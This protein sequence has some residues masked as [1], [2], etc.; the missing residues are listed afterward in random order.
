MAGD[1]RITPL[2]KGF[3]TSTYPLEEV[4]GVNLERKLYV[5]SL[6][7]EKDWTGD[8]K[9]LDRADRWAKQVAV[10]SHAWLKSAEKD[11]VEAS[12]WCGNDVG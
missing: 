1:N 10:G 2:I 5:Q 9:R 4:R 7:I 3:M 12:N 6:M 11:A 8:F